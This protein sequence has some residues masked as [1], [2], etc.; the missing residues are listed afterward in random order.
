MNEGFDAFS[1][2]CAAD[3]ENL[4]RSRGRSAGESLGS[5]VGVAAWIW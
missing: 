3:V 5:A 1:W 2:N 4:D